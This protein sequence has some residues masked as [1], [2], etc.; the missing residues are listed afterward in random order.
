MAAEKEMWGCR[1]GAAVVEVAD[2]REGDPVFVLWKGE[3][4]EKKAMVKRWLR[5]G[6]LVCAAAIGG[7]GFGGS[8]WLVK[9]EER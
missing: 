5:P 9:K 6:A 7:R 8:N 2:Q 1:G 3:L 4:E